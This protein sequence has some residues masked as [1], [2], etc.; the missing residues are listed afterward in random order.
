MYVFFAATVNKGLC[1]LYTMKCLFLPKTHQNAFADR[2]P[3]PLAG[4]RGRTRK[5]EEGTDGNGSEW[6]EEGGRRVGIEVDGWT[7][8]AKSRVHYCMFLSNI[9]LVCCVKTDRKLEGA[10]ESAYLRQVLAFNAEKFWGSRDPSHASIWI[11]F[12]GSCPVCPWEHLCQTWSPYSVALIVFELLA[13]NA[14]KFRGSRVPGHAPFWKN[15]WGSC[16]NCPWEHFC[17]ISSP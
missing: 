10:H 3:Q 14:E 11:N 17:Q 13:F 6:K 8:I 9:S 15:F 2:T 5:G 4:L 16:P 7:L 1:V 12:W